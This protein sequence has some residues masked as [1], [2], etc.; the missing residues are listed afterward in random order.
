MGDTLVE[1]HYNHEQ[2]LHEAT[3]LAQHAFT[4]SP[5]AQTIRSLILETVS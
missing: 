5:A 3:Q 1:L 2:R 4:I